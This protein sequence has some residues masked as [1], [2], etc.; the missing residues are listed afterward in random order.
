MTGAILQRG[1]VVEVTDV[2]R[3]LPRT[4]ESEGRVFLAARTIDG[5]YFEPIGPY[6]EIV[7]LLFDMGLSPTGIRRAGSPASW[8]ADVRG[9][10]L[11]VRRLGNRRAAEWLPTFA[12]A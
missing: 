4:L 9:S 6:E 1:F 3:A 7:S 5:M 2:P 11:A 8:H 10:R 12:P